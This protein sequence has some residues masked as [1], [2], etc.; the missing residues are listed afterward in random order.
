[1]AKLIPFTFLFI[2][3]GC[4]GNPL[5]VEKIH[6]LAPD[7]TKIE[8]LRWI[9]S[10]WE[11]VTPNGKLYEV[12][13]QKNDTTYSGVSFFVAEGDTLFTE[14]I[15]L[16]L[17]KGELYYIPTVSNQNNA[18]PITFTLIS[19]ANTEFTFENKNHDFPQRIVYKNSTPDKLDAR[20]E[21]VDNGK[22]RKEEFYM[23]R[24]KN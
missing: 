21:G 23:V 14:S 17:S 15:L 11:G 9:I 16:V 10:K 13:T 2:L 20:I 6:E 4:N 19:V 22:F 3:I 24:C 5:N 7:L 8:Q 1:M 18:S 12:W